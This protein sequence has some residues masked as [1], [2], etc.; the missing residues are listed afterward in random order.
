M[1]STK[2]S[3]QYVVNAVYSD[4][5]NFPLDLEL[6][7]KIEEAAGTERIGSGSGFG[8]RD[9]QFSARNKV[10]AKEMADRISLIPNVKVNYELE[11]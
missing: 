6:D 1:T 8:E 4:G 2:Y 5:S 3:S 9:I 10:E 11:E 7:K